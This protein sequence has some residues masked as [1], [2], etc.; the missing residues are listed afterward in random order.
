M[1]QQGQELKEIKAALINLRL[2]RDGEIATDFSSIPTLP[3][4]DEQLLKNFE[5]RL[6]LE[7][8]RSVLVID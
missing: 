4:A 5:E 7:S 3:I 6:T 1:E 8:N 2:N